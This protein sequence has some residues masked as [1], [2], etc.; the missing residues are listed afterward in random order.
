MSQVKDET[1]HKYVRSVENEDLF[2]SAEILEETNDIVGKESHMSYAWGW[3]AVQL[4]M[5][6]PDNVFKDSKADST[7]IGVPDITPEDLNRALFVLRFHHRQIFRQNSHGG[8]KTRRQKKPAEKVQYQMES[9]ETTATCTITLP[10]ET[11]ALN[12]LD[13]NFLDLHDCE[14]PTGDVGPD[15]PDIYEDPV[16]FLTG[17]CFWRC[18]SLKKAHYKFIRLRCS[19]LF[20]YIFF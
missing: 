13:E 6:S 5:V 15:E 18:D 17:G 12:A 4:I 10:T 11:N 16:N 3:F 14:P 20:S 2:Q 19:S 1:V 9:T 8:K 7:P